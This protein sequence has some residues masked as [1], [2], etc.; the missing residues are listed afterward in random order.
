MIRIV[1][2]AA[3]AFALASAAP[4]FAGCPDCKD[5]PQ[6]KT[7]AADKAEKKDKAEPKAAVACPCAG[8]GKECKCGPT[9][10]CPHC[11]AK[12]A[13]KQAEPKKS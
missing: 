8:E 13:E 6:H 9:C 11:H 4:A 12:K 2:A 7:A 5:C 3:A 1:L 10:E